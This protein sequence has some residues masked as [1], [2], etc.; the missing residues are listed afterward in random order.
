M[1]V[2]LKGG[3]NFNGT[4]RLINRQIRS[5]KNASLSLLFKSFSR[6]HNNHQKR[7]RKL[8]KQQRNFTHCRIFTIFIEMNLSEWRINK[9]GEA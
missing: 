4:L 8:R 6:A 7:E 5:F 3:I 2:I 1:T 9:K